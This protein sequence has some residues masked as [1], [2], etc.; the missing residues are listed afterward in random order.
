M[1]RPAAIATPHKRNG[2]WYLAHSGEGDQW[3]RRMATTT[4]LPVLDL[5]SA[6]NLRA[7]QRGM[8]VSAYSTFVIAL[9]KLAAASPLL[10]LGATC[11]DTASVQTPNHAQ[12]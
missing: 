1:A 12:L 11:P 5:F 10:V 4:E 7:Q 9:H 6:F 8:L 2:Y 3:F